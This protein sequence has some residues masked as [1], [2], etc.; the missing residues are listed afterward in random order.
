LSSQQGRLAIDLSLFAGIFLSLLSLGTFS[1]LGFVNPFG[2]S[3]DFTIASLYDF[4]LFGGI[5]LICG[6]LAYMKFGLGKDQHK[7]P[8]GNLLIDFMFVI[9]FFLFVAGQSI[10]NSPFGGSLA[11]IDIGYAYIYVGLA[12]FASSL[13]FWNKERMRGNRVGLGFEVMSS[14]CIA[15]ILADVFVFSYGNIAI[16]FEIPFGAFEVLVACII[17]LITS[18]SGLIYARKKRLVNFV[19]GVPNFASVAQKSVRHGRIVT[20]AIVAVIAVFVFFGVPIIPMN[21]ACIHGV[22]YPITYIAQSGYVC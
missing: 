16:P 19:N 8:S 15:L 13:Y 1:W 21:N 3:S 10:Y 5:F 14:L 9:G 11:E 7:I 22:F 6:S 2:F 20:Y 12:L 18:V 17:G 4:V